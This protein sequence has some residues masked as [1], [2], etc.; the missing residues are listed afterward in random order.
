MDEKGKE[1]IKK[2]EK[3]FNSQILKVPMKLTMNY[4]LKKH[5]NKKNRKNKLVVKYIVRRN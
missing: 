1:M 3:T 4:L 2:H 5:K